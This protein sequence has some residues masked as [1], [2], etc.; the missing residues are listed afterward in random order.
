MKNYLKIAIVAIALPLQLLGQVLMPQPQ[1]IAFHTGKL[2]LK[3]GTSFTLIGP[4]KPQILQ[5]MDRANKRMIRLFGTS[6]GAAIKAKIDSAKPV[7]AYDL[8]INSDG[9]FISAG[10]P[11][12][13]LWAFETLTQL[14]QKEA[15][16]LYL[17]Y[18]T[19]ND[20]PKFAWRGMMVDVA[21]HFIPLDILKRNVDAMA[22]AKMN[23]L[24]LHL[25][26][27]EGFRI[28]SKRF[29][30]LHELGSEGKYFTQDQIKELVQYCTERGIM[31]YPEFDLPGHSQSWFAGYPELASEEKSYKPGPRFNFPTGTSMAQAMQMIATAPTP[32]IDPTKESTYE[33]LDSFLAEMK[34]LF[35]SGYLH[36][37][38]DE[39]NGVAWKNNPKIVSFMSDNK[40]ASTH[41]LQD[42]F[43]QRVNKIA[44]KHGFT[45][46]A[47][48]EAFNEKTPKN[49]L[50]QA[51]KPDMMGPGLGLE[52]IQKQGN[53]GILSRG[54]YLDLFLPAYM[55]YS[56][57]DLTQNSH[58]R[59]GEAAIWTELVDENVFENRV[60]PRSLAI[61][62]RL[63]S[64]PE[65]METDDLYRRLFQTEQYLSKLGL[66]GTKGKM[67]AIAKYPSLKHFLPIL[68]PIRGYK[69]L[70]G[71]MLISQEQ[72]TKTFTELRDVL[73]ADS[74]EAFEF[75]MKVKAF[76]LDG[77]KEA[78]QA[79]L[80]NW[81]SID[82][83]VLPTLAP[84][85]QRFKNISQKTLL[86]LENKQNISTQELMAEIK[87]ARKSA[88]GLEVNI[89]DEIEAI[90]SGQ[91]KER[92]KTISLL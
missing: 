15:N 73:P 22:A 42:Y 30:K 29:P 46:I 57:K 27:D 60:W 82:T 16:N 13:V 45:P 80:Q 40:I 43:L 26:D 21:R 28:E 88:G 32:T 85:A 36:W 62:E 37:G 71:E 61:A 49:I 79:E 91:L 41:E 24:H 59:G 89:W 48:E 76:L 78:I 7:E 90:V 55:H 20:Y 77:K 63:W 64:N 18:L 83:T 87:S 35:P 9:I 52:A 25:S 75:R 65:K 12:G 69:R 19:I 81:A 53:E 38:L 44:I 92:P 50:I 72:K 5:A 58:W 4:H 39:N 31:V 8:T 23:V 14:P 6:A 34:P 17:P 10:S 84:L 51:W 74:K 66:Q 70:M 2:S 54:F 86:F 47:W 33:F 3:K 68:T 56:N 1:K 67:D 11:A